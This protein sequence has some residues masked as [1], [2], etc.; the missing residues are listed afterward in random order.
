MM[1]KEVSKVSLKKFSPSAEETKMISEFEKYALAAKEGV[2]TSC[3]W[4]NGVWGGSG[5]DWNDRWDL[6]EKIAIMWFGPSDQSDGYRSNVKSP[7][8]T[9]RISGTMQK[10]MKTDIKYIGRPKHPDD[11]IQAKLAEII[12]NQFVKQKRE[13]YVLRDIFYDSLVHGTAYAT[14]DHVIKTR[15]V[16]IPKEAKDMTDKEKTAVKKDGKLAYKEVVHVD[17][18]GPSLVPRRIQEILLDPD[19]RRVH[20]EAHNAAYYI[21][22]VPMQYD[23]FLAK[24]GDKPGYRNVYSVPKAGDV[25]AQDDDSFFKPPSSFGGDY[26]RL[27]YLYH[28][29]KDLMWV[30]ANGV[31][32]YDGPLP[33]NHK[34]LNLIDFCPMRLPHSP[35]GI[36]LVDLLLP[37]VTTMETIQN[38]VNDHLIYSTVPMYMVEKSDY[39]E[40]TNAAVEARPGQFLPVTDTSSVAPLKM[41]PLTMDVFQTLQLLERDAIK[42]SQQDPSQ[43]GVVVKNA[44]ATANLMNREIVDAYVNFVMD[45]FIESLSVAA[46]QKWSLIRQF[47]SKKDV[48]KLLKSGGQ[49]DTSMTKRIRLD[50]IEVDIDWDKKRVNVIERPGKVSFLDLDEKMLTTSEDLEITVDPESVQILS[51]ALEVQKMKEAFAQLSPYFVDPND[52]QKLAQH[53]APWINGPVMVQQ[54]YEQIGL[55]KKSLINIVQQEEEQVEMAEE[56]NRRMLELEA[57]PGEPGMGVAHIDVHKEFLKILNSRLEE[58]QTLLTELQPLVM[59]APDQTAFIQMQALMQEQARLSQAVRLLAAHVE[60]DSMPAYVSPSETVEQSKGLTQPPTAPMPQGVGGGGGVGGVG[61]GFGGNMPMPAGGGP[62]QIGGM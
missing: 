22:E 16:R 32:I 10:L 46:S 57:V 38:L 62:G 23:R 19:A 14:L 4:E 48:E 6:Q 35:Y 51:E 59:Q 27:H 56:Q 13:R 45:S 55:D 7:E 31:P 47:F 11:E 21:L 26:V 20:G 43:L 40:F 28:Y 60:V 50:G 29:D 9:A 37:V 18:Y 1:N 34:Q 44:T 2:Q 52:K 5:G 54:Y 30:F 49:G 25:E 17:S 41:L 3:Y 12:L 61:S 39:Q 42:V 24:F 53:P 36:G 8:V 58:I 15:K 33:Y